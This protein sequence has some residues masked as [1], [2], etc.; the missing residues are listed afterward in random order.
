MRCRE[1]ASFC[2]GVIF[3]KSIDP[4]PVVGNPLGPASTV[5][6]TTDPAG[7]PPLRGFA[8]SVAFVED[9]ANDTL[10]PVPA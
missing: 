7:L 5:L 1:Y 4:S 3:L 9:P 2:A 6:A 8:L 10:D